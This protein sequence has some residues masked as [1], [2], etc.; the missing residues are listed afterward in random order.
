MASSLFVNKSV[1]PDE[2]KLADSLAKRQLIG[3]KLKI[4]L[5][6]TM[7]SWLK[8]GNSIIRNLVGY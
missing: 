6:S 4:I 7:V 5:K 2:Q 8:N 1:K 3:R